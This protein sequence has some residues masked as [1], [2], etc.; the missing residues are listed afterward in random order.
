MV[1]SGSS[2]SLLATDEVLHLVGVE[3]IV[4]DW[5]ADPAVAMIHLNGFN[6]LSPDVKIYCAVQGLAMKPIE[7]C[8][9]E[10]MEDDRF[11]RKASG[12]WQ[13]MENM[14]VDMLA[15]SWW[16]GVHRSC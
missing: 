4:A 6:K 12:L 3:Q 7:A 14:V 9:L 15:F 8:V 13:T 2:Q 11:L 1:V 5:S 16:F 10:L